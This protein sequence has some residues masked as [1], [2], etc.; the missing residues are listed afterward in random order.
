[1]STIKLATFFFIILTTYS[2]SSQEC[3]VKKLSSIVGKQSTNLLM[4]LAQKANEEQQKHAN[5]ILVK[6]TRKLTSLSDKNA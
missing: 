2:L 6:S 4:D 5:R 1:M 3:V